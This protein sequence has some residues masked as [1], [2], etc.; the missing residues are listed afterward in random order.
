MSYEWSWI[1]ALGLVLKVTLVLGI[2]GV[3]AVA[4]ARSSAATRH[5]VWLMALGGAVAIPLL[6][7]AVPQLRVPVPVASL[8]AESRSSLGSPTATREVAHWPARGVTSVTLPA[9]APLDPKPATGLR[10]GVIIA[11]VW[12]LGC[13]VVIVRCVAAHIGVARLVRAAERLESEHWRRL[14]RDTAARTGVRRRVTVMLSDAVGG[15]ITSGLFRPVV[16]LPADA[17]TWTAERREVVLLH[18]LA[19]VARLDYAAQLIATAGWRSRDTP[20]TSAGS[21]GASCRRPSRGRAD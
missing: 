2:A 6:T 10:A 13:I 15:P 4:L 5:L 14:L 21:R 11:I 3:L 20:C 1:L 9:V 16:L 8:P 12:L 19:H 18:E 7:P 17:E